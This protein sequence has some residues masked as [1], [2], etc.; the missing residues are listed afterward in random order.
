V[1]PLV[2]LGICTAFKEDLQ[3]SVAELVYGKPQRIP[4]KMLTPTADP[5]DPAHFITEL[6]HHMAHLGPILAIRHAF[7]A[8]FVHSD[9]ETCTH[10]LLRQDTT[11]KTMEPPYS[12]SYQVLSRGEK[13]MNILVC[14]RPV[15]VSTDRVKPA[16][17]LN[18][19]SHG[20]TTK[21]FNPAADATP[22]A[23]PHAVPPPPIIR[24]TE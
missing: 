19:T 9:L 17:M 12:G 8:T 15:T 2:L 20:T 16:Y 23:D 7:P 4:G 22:A 10:V 11:R 1:L 13:I 18:D 24:T 3:A 5:V 14:G 21:T 6:R